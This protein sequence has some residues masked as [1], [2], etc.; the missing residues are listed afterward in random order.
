M[1]KNRGLTL[2]S[3][4][5]LFRGHK[6][7]LTLK[8]KIHFDPSVILRK[9]LGFSASTPSPACPIERSD[10]FN[11][12]FGCS[13]ETVSMLLDNV[14][15]DFGGVSLEAVL[16]T[17]NFFHAFPN[18]MKKKAVFRNESFGNSYTKHREVVAKIASTISGVSSSLPVAV[19]ILN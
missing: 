3:F 2:N 14:E 11:D 17:L 8:M 19:S 4:D 1:Q 13:P 10:R 7:L 15:F 9:G 5:L 18:P 12:L 6:S 16:A